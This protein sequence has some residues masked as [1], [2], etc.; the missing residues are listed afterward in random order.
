MY[1]GASDGNPCC[2][3]VWLLVLAEIQIEL[4]FHV[5]RRMADFGSRQPTGLLGKGPPQDGGLFASQ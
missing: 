5:L 2:L 1:P 3:L 4:H